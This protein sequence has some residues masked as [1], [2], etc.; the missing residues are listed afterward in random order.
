MTFR[1]QPLPELE[2]GFVSEPASPEAIDRF[3]A[4]LGESPV[5]PSSLLSERAPEGSP[6]ERL[7]VT[8]AGFR[9]DLAEEERRLRGFAEAAGFSFPD[10]VEGRE[11]CRR[12]RQRAVDSEAPDRVALRAFIA[13]GTLRGAL[14]RFEVAA[15]EMRMTYDVVADRRTGQID[16]LLGA[17]AD[18]RA[19]VERFRGAAVTSGGRL[20]VTRWPV[21][22]PPAGSERL[23]GPPPGTIDLMRA[24]KSRLD[25]ERRLNPGLYLW[26]L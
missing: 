15:A 26:G 13:I 4:A 14:E 1:V 6:G 22:A 12:L 5:D 16:L 18:P 2:F 24:L 7:I 10:K 17:S 9:E 25:P 23:L 11:A 3:V 8:L 19:A 20:L 21:S